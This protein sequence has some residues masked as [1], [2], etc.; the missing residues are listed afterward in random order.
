MALSVLNL[1]E[2][3]KEITLAVHYFPGK[4]SEWYSQNI[5]WLKALSLYA[6]DLFLSEA[7][8]AG[9]LKDAQESPGSSTLIY[10]CTRKGTAL[11]K[12]Y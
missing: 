11:A 2:K 9:Y 7:V 10:R 8:R 6:T 12:N 5:D 4:T 3:A 1:P